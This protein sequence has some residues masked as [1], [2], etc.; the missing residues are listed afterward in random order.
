M[1]LRRKG[2][3]EEDEGLC[4]ICMDRPLEAQI[5]G[6]DHQVYLHSAFS[7]CNVVLS[8][9]KLSTAGITWIV[10]LPSAFM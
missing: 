5:S 8:H 1:P 9:V 3:R 2:E 10:I 6:C 4:S 7:P